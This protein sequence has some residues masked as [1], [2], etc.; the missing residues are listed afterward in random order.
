MSPRARH[1]KKYC[2]ASLLPS[3][4]AVASQAGQSTGLDSEN[5]RVVFFTVRR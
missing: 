3:H 2:K 1:Q 4:E 5:L